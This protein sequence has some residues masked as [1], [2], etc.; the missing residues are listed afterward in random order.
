MKKSKAIII[1]LCALLVLLGVGY[2]DL[3]GVDAEGTASASDISLGLDLAGG[4]SI[5]YQVVGDEEPDATDMAD[6]IAKLQKRVENYSKEAIVYQEGTDRINIEIPGVTDANKILE[7]LGRP[8]SLYFIAET[9]KDGNANYSMQAVTDA[10]GNVSYAYALNKTIDELKAD[11]SIMLEGTDV[12][13]ATAGSIKDQTMGNSTY[14]V[15]L[16]MTE[17]GT[18][19]FE[20][21][22]RNAYEKGETL[23]IYYDGSFVSVPSVKGVFSDGN[24]QISPMSSYE[25]AESLASTIRIGGLKLELEELHSKVVGAQLGVEAISTSLKAAV[26]GFIVVAV[27]MIAVYFLPG[28]AS[29]IALGIYVAL[30]V[31]LLNGFDMTLT[32]SGIAG[33]ILS[34]GMA[35]D[36]NVIVFARIREELATGKTVKSAMQIGYDKAL[37][38]IIDGNVTTLIAAAVLWLLGPGTVKGFA[39]TLALGIVLSMFTALVVT[40][41]IMKAFYALGLKDPKWYGVGKEHKTVNFLGKKGI[42]FGLSL[43]VIAVGFITMGVYKMNTGDALNYSLEFKGGTA[44]TVTFDKSYTLEEINSEMVPLI[45]STTGS[46]VQ[47]QTVQGSNEVIFKTGSLDVDQRQALNQMF[48]D[49]FGVDETLITSETISSTISNE[50]KSDTILAVAVAIIC[51]LIYIRFRFSDIRFGVSSIACL[52]HD[53]LVVIT[54]YALARVSVSNTFIACLLT[55]VGYSINAT[56]VVFDRVRENMAVMTKKDDL[57]EVV[58]RSIT[59]TLSRS[60]FT[61][62]TTLV[63]VGALYIWGVTS[64]R[65]FALPL[66]VGIICGAYS[67][68]CV[69]GALWYVLRKKFAPKAK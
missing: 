36:A 41:Y 34:I 64:I 31:L 26:I 7:E 53:V 1:L 8:G 52:L 46:A 33:I 28:F 6:T 44:T 23:G 60:L 2:V 63:M 35:V 38:A 49:N 25:E 16:V 17:E 43:A 62:L 66:M 51:M 32:L 57:Q 24:A 11:G 58:N 54:F 9:D 39:Q 40:K 37:S 68:V 3:N 67:S 4:V 19:K 47:I 45:E 12:K 65:D 5:T 20:E 56:I 29:V 30:V 15:D 13:T 27:F 59:Q 10:Q 22:T 14:A 18:K 48:V 21:A 69:A 55:I 61:S 50:M 42:F